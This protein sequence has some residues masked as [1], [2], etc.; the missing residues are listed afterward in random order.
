PAPQ[1][2]PADTQPAYAAPQPVGAPSADPFSPPIAEDD[3]EDAVVVEDAI[4]VTDTVIVENGQVVAE[5]ISVIEPHHAEAYSGLVARSA[6]RAQVRER[7]DA[8][9]ESI[10]ETV[11]GAAADRGFELTERADVDRG[12]ELRFD[13]ASGD[14]LVISLGR[15]AAS[16]IEDIRGEHLPLTVSY[17][18][19]AFEGTAD[20]GSG[21]HGEVRI[22]SDEWTG[23]ATSTV[24]LF[25]GVGDYF[26]ESL[27]LDEDGLVLDVVATIATVQ[28][29]LS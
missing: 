24:S 10:V 18:S 28:Q 6:A 12:H 20:D 2:A 4:V 23:Q 14:L 13:A 25:L 27:E 3:I 15:V 22:V 9:D 7:V 26:S 11:I 8:V 1:P 21:Q 5:S 16:R 19:G 29:R 17:R